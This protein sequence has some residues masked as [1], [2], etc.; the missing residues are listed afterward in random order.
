MLQSQ[1]RTE[2]Q[3]R[4]DSRQ[5]TLPTPPPKTYQTPTKSIW[6][7]TIVPFLLLLVCP[8]FVLVIYAVVTYLDGS[9]QQLATAAG[10]QT[11][12]THLPM[13]SWT[14]AG[15]IAIFVA[16][17]LMLLF[18]LPG[19][20]MLGPMTPTGHRPAY[21]LNGVAAFFVTHGL[22]W[23]CAGPLH[24]FSPAVIYDH[25]GALLSTLCVFALLF[26]ALLYAK[27]YLFP[28]NSDTTISGN[29]IFDYFQGVELHPR[30]FGVDLKQLCNSRI[31]MM[32]WS[33]I[34]VSFGAAQHRIHGHLSTGMA[35][36]IFLQ[37]AYLLKF[38]VW[39]GG[40]FASLDITHDRFGFYICWG[41]LCWVPCLY[42][43]ATFYMTTH[44]ADLSP[45]ATAALL[46][47][48]VGALLVNYLAD[49]QRQRVRLTGGR[50][51]VWGRPP[52]LIE[53]SY[54]T[55]DGTR[56]TNLLLAS[57]YWGLAR[58]FHY[59]PELLLALAWTIPAGTT[60]VLP[61]FYWMFLFVL[62]VDR[63]GRDDR[64][65]ATKYG[66]SWLAYREAVPY[67]ILPGVY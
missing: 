63:A 62:L 57:G 55:T 14:A 6:R 48:G 35:V 33:I 2:D 52:R 16:V 29:P 66:D 27:G 11:V 26:C 59:V 50:T 39:E 36:S 5:P 4:A 8:P 17:A 49:R 40:Y 46:A 18:F 19:A 31:S 51:T 7:M 58:H 22:F 32:A 64:R 21:R 54:S 12:L 43:L 3:P 28:T 25:F 10:L 9:V 60:H 56:Q 41:V 67:K 30:L 38:F 37:C 15:M 13:P 42:T 23:L 65:C 61:Y 1:A 24:L 34:V 20:R 45:L 44:P 53:A 47:F